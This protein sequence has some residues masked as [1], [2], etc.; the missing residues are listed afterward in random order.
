V[1]RNKNRGKKNKGGGQKCRGWGGEGG[2]S[3]G[4]GGGIRKRQGGKSS[5]KSGPCQKTKDV[6]KCLGVSVKEFQ[7]IRQ[8]GGIKKGLKEALVLQMARL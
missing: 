8:P 4:K 1:A 7:T 6:K 3:G 5:E 2:V